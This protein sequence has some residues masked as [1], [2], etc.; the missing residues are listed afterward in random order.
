MSVGQNVAVF[1]NDKAGT[2]CLLSLR[3]QGDGEGKRTLAGAGR[4]GGF[5]LYHTMRVALVDLLGGQNAALQR[6][7]RGTRPLSDDHRL[8]ALHGQHT[9]DREDHQDEERGKHTAHK[10]PN[11]RSHN[12]H[13][14]TS[15]SPPHKDGHLRGAAQKSTEEVEIQLSIR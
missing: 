10:E 6:R 12:P 2:Q 9:C 4:E 11:A 1:R 8:F 13:G 5:D 3:T 15:M 14:D 7:H